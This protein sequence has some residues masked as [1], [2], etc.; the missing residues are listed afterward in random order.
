MVVKVSEGANNNAARAAQC[1]M[2]KF[3][4]ID[5][6]SSFGNASKTATEKFQKAMGINEVTGSVD[7]T[8]WQYLFGYNMYPNSG[9]KDAYAS[10]CMYG[11][12]LS[13]AQMTTNA[14][15]V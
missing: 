11:S 14:K 12:T 13:D 15:Y 2:N 6:D 4:A 9:S 8:T 7:A 3:E 5:V 10:V 1:L